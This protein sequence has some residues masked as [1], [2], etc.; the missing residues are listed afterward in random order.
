ML[1]A[2]AQSAQQV[3]RK[4]REMLS[5]EHSGGGA[6]KCRGPEVGVRDVDTGSQEDQQV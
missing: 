2:I 6:S 3:A 5:E 4:A 1:D